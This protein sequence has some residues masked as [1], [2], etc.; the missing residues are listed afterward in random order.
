MQ[1]QEDLREH[2]NAQCR[3]NDDELETY[4][5]LHK[6][7]MVDSLWKLSV[8]DVEATSNALFLYRVQS[9]LLVVTVVFIAFISISS[10]EYQE[11]RTPSSS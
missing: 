5:L 3:Y 10:H 2:L 4:M 7:A 11:R 8:G 6:S 9:L 1:L